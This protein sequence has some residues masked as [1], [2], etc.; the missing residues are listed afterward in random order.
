MI[1]YSIVTFPQ[2]INVDHRKRTIA[3]GGNNNSLG[4]AMIVDELV[5]I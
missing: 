4:R 3:F 5:R 2:R 1:W